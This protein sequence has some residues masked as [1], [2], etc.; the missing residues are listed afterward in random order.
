MV[1]NIAEPLFG[2][3][4][5]CDGRRQ[6]L[7]GNPLNLTEECGLQGLIAVV[8]SGI[9]GLC[10]ALRISFGGRQHEPCRIGICRRCANAI[11]AVQ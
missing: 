4:H 9:H 5:M 1:F 11:F 7:V 3:E 8:R 10:G 6:L 2:G